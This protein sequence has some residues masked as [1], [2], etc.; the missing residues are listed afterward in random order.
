MQKV[1]YTKWNSCYVPVVVF[2]S[3]S[4]IV[5]PN[6]SGKSNVI[7]S[8]LF[9]FGYRASKIRSKKL[10][11]LIHNSENHMNLT[12]CT[13]AV[14][15][16]KIIDTGVRV[17]GGS[18][19]IHVG[20][21]PGG[22]LQTQGYVS[23]GV[24]TH[25]CGYVSRGVTTD[26]GVRVQGSHCRHRGTCPGGSLPIHVGTC[27]GGVTT[28]TCGYVS[29]GGHYPYMW[30]RVQGGH[31]RHR[32]TCPGGSLPIHVGMC[33]GGSLQTQGYVSRGVTA[34]TGV[35]VRGGHYPYMWVH[36]R[37][38]HYPYMWVHVQGGHYP[39]MWVHVQGGHYPYMWVGVCSRYWGT[40][41]QNI[42]IP[43][44]CKPCSLFIC[45]SNNSALCFSKNL[46]HNLHVNT[47][48]W[49]W[50]VTGQFRL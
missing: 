6:G 22:S 19:P 33:P 11:V 43:H 23:R 40:C 16:Q 3:F 25:T 13:V 27:P 34:D 14:H 42:A 44:T 8:M 28:H 5:G 10:S 21:C 20:T 50:V 37:G 41:L 45:H 36:V 35:R 39:Y 26:T 47:R 30:V 1:L 29:R 48:A 4:S 32:G 31:Y 7:D 18:L 38:G 24:T 46:S 2:Q 49:K 12:A 15:F 17:Q 9:V